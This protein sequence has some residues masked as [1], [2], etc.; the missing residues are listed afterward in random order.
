MTRGVIDKA[1]LV[2]L[3][4]TNE[5]LKSHVSAAAV[6][7]RAGDAGILLGPL[8]GRQE[9]EL[10][11]PMTE[12]EIDVMADMGDFDDMPPEVEEAGGAFRT[13]YDN[14]LSR[15]QRSEQAAGFFRTFEAAVPVIQ[16]KPEILELFDFDVAI[17]ELANINAVPPKW[18][19]DPEALKALR[20]QRASQ[21]EAAAM[22]EA[23]PGIAG[24]VKDISQAQAAG[25]GIGF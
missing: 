20:E 25:G 13:R 7:K 24:A 16:A 17:P 21:E 19:T 3:L 5:E 2:H 4:D 8:M 6:M 18:M 22:V 14:P 12:R 1:F 9:T 23:A 15:M 10:L 11:D